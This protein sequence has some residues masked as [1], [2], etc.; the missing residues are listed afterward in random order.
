[1]LSQTLSRGASAL[2]WPLRDRHGRYAVGWIVAA[3]LATWA[4]WMLA[5][6]LF[7][8]MP[9]LL[10]LLWIP[11]VGGAF[12]WRY[13]GRGSASGRRRID[14]GANFG[15]ASAPLVAAGALLIAVFGQFWEIVYRRIPGIRP[16][17]TDAWDA[18]ASSPVG[19]AAVSL[20]LVAVVPLME[21]FCFR[22]WILRA[23]VPRCG[24]RTALAGSSLLFA[25]AHA[26]ISWI[27][28]YF[29][30]GLILAWAVHL[31]GS[32]WTGVALHAGYNAMCVALEPLFPTPEAITAWSD[33][34]GLGYWSAPLAMAASLA[35]LAGLALRVR[36]PRLARGA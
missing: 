18:Y 2:L 8:A 13:A 19:V 5:L 4:A 15:E 29:V 25:A 34:L 16:P 20:V 14:P 6:L 24:A 3:D 26:W 32:V 21:E 33:G 10:A 1:M 35:A 31:S 7:L 11:V 28:Y 22:G 27:P 9:P 36:R 30:A 23:L 17:P 12:A